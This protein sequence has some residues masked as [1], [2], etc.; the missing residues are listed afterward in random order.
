MK[1][2]LLIL[3]FIFIPYWSWAQFQFDASHYE[4]DSNNFTFGLRS[5]AYSNSNALTSSALNKSLFGGHITETEKNQILQRSS[6]V[7]RSGVYL[8]TSIYFVQR[9]DSLFKKSQDQLSYFI[10]VSDRQEYITAYTDNF[11]KLVLFGN[12]Q[13][14]GQSVPLAPLDFNSLHYSQF[15]IGFNTTTQSGN[16][17]TVGISFLYGQ[18]QIRGTAERFDLLVSENGDRIS[19]DTKILINQSELN[20]NDYMSYN[21]A[22]ASFDF[23]GKFKIALLHDTTNKATFHFSITDLGFIQWN[24]K[25]QETK[26][27][28]FYTYNGAHIT[29]IFDPNSP[30]HN[31]N[32]SKIWDSISTTTNLSYTSSTP[33]TLRFYLEQDWKKWIFT[34]G[35]THRLNGFYVPYVYGKAGYNLN[36]NW[37]ISGQLNYGGYG[38]FG[39]GLAVNY[40]GRKYDIKLGSTNITGFIAPQTVAGQ[41]IYV[42][43][44]MKI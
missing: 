6:P 43:L 10:N 9:I 24:G 14:A 4:L 44:K 41:S 33:V 40:I 5:E 23:T 21:G 32:P 25:S 31:E 29:N 36:K 8:N 17:F 11:A 26:V 30:T 42:L 37:L 39:G 22:G 34:L 7:N 20:N 38:N 3:V 13:F 1:L 2:K 19:T 15:Q 18:N 35:V 16:I 27:D 12:K 28:T